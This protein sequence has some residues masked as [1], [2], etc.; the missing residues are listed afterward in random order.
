MHKKERVLFMSLRKVAVRD[1][2]SISL[3]PFSSK[4]C[5]AKFYEVL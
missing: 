2:Y 5:W 3:G 1:F 4:S